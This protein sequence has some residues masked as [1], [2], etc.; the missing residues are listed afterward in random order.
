[1]PF[2]AA[3]STPTGNTHTIPPGEPSQHPKKQKR[4]M[5]PTFSFSIPDKQRTP[6]SSSIMSENSRNTR[7]VS[8]SVSVSVST[9]VKKPRRPD[10]ANEENKSRLTFEQ[11]EAWVRTKFSKVSFSFKI[12]LFHDAVLR[13]TNLLFQP[14]IVVFKHGTVV[15]FMTA[16]GKEFSKE[17]LAFEAFLVLYSLYHTRYETIGEMSRDNAFHSDVLQDLLPEITISR[18][19]HTVG[20]WRQMIWQNPIDRHP[21]TITSWVQTDLQGQSSETQCSPAGICAR[22]H[23][24]LYADFAA[25]EI[26]FME[27]DT[28]LREVSCQQCHTKLKPLVLPENS[29][30]CPTCKAATYC[31]EQCQ[32]RDASSHAIYCPLIGQL[33]QRQTTVN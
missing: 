17:T 33:S 1:M 7:S 5:E 28:R 21:H 26:T 9:P 31:S 25:R 29:F 16:L 12:S 23:M 10:F 15:T 11:Y 22:A 30:Q 32:K 19:V 27:S 18:P 24:N 4:Q 13:N 6:L 20:N 2:R 8:A 14:Q 3:G